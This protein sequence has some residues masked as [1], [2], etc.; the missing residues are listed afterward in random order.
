MARCMKKRGWRREESERLR[1]CALERA[2]F[3]PPGPAFSGNKRRAMSLNFELLH[4]KLIYSQFSPA[5]CKIKKWG[6]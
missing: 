1:V 3:P 4:K 6:F 2:F 5:G